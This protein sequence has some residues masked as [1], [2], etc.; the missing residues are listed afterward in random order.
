MNGVINMQLQDLIELQAGEVVSRLAKH[1]EIGETGDYRIYDKQVFTFEAGSFDESDKARFISFNDGSQESRIVKAGDGIISI[2]SSEMSVSMGHDE[3]GAPLMLTSNFM[4]VRPKM[5]NVLDMY[6][7]AFWFNND[8]EALRQLQLAG[9]V[10]STLIK[11]LNVKQI[12]G[13]EIT[14]PDIET[15]RAIGA[16]YAAELTRN[17]AAEERTKVSHLVAME[18]IRQINENVK[19]NN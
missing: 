7:L 13:L 2:L 18:E 11:R 19:G 4:I 8:D 3:A 1:G 12:K 16:M 14:L 17:R 10:S 6:Y 9:E 15:Q 5:E